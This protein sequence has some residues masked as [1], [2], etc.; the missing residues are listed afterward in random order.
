MELSLMGKIIV[1]GKIRVLTGLHIGGAPGSLDIGGLDNSVVKDERGMP[2]IPGSSLKGKMRSLLEQYE[3]HLRPDRLIRLVEAKQPIRI[4]MCN[5]ETCSVCTI[6]GRADGNR[7]LDEPLPG[8]QGPNP[9]RRSID[10]NVTTPTRLQVRD[11]YLIEDSVKPFQKYL[12]LDYT[13]VKFE[14][15]IDRIT[16]A[17]NPRQTERVPRGAEFAFEMAFTVLTEEDKKMF[18]K[19][20]TAMRLLEDDYLGGSGSRGYGKI[21]FEEMTVHWRSKDDYETGVFSDEPIA[22]GT[23]DEVLGVDVASQLV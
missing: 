8:Q 10:V 7:T 23:L 4:H 16:S 12:D 11:A 3:G 6:F 5:S 18:S 17:A 9:R 19:V 14:N 2:Y 22:S 15:S 21:A 13:E 1:V 20:L